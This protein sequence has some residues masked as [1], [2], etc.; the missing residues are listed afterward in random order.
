VGKARKGGKHHV[1]TNFKRGKTGRNLA[2][3]SVRYIQHRRR[4][5]GGNM[6]RTLF[7]SHGLMDKHAVYA[8]IDCSHRAAVSDKCILSPDP[9]KE[10]TGK[11]VG[12]ERITRQ[13]I[14]ALEKHFD[15]A[16]KEAK[17]A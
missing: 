13:T 16:G 3:A 10:D 4:R 14:L 5:G 15:Q 11:D 8:L 7:G 2:K 1:M 6:P 9:A 17:T 12:I